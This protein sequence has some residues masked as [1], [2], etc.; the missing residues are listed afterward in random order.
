M[1]KESKSIGGGVDLPDSGNRGGEGEAG[2]EAGEN[3]RV[4]INLS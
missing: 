1:Y 2:L 3:P 4:V